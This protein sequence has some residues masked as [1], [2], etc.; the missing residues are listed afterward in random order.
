MILADCILKNIKEA[1]QVTGLPYD[2]LYGIVCQESSGL[3]MAVRYEPG[4]FKRYIMKIPGL[5]TK[6]SRGRST[7]WGLMQVMGQV[8][9][10]EGFTGEFEQLLDPRV[11]LH[12]GCRH[13]LV[14]KKRH[15]TTHGWPGVIAAYNAGSPRK[16]GGVYVNQHYVDKVYRYGREARWPL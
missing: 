12:W 11:G 6:E 9:R 14:L 1:A 15:L 2:L 10:E 4:F 3:P 7:S 13:L 5:G 16:K 8:A